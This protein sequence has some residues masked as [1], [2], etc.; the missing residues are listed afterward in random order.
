MD[1]APASWPCEICDKPS[2]ARVHPGCQAAI[3]EHLEA[4][5]KLYRALGAFLAPGRTPATGGR[6][7]SRTAPLPARL[8]VLDLRSR[9]GIEGVLGTWEADV[10]EQLGWTPAVPRGSVEAAVEAHASFLRANLIW[11]CDE[12][13]AVREF[14]ADVRRVAGQARAIAMG[15]APERRVGVQCGCGGV[16]HVTVSTDGAR[17]EDCGTQY[18][19]MEV[20]RLPL[21][22]R[23]GGVAA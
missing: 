1:T 21:A 10:R 3:D 6:S 23:S 13:P 20:T 2:R 17:C 19:R 14:G 15:G 11:I 16:L 9:G 18:G 8:E 4:L 22:A 12:H 7:G 5:P